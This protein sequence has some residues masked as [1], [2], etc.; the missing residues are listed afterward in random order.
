[1]FEGVHTALITPFDEAREFDETAFRAIIDEQFENGISGIVP[2]GTTGESPTLNNAEHRRV[3][4]HAALHVT[5]NICRSH[6]AFGVT[7]TVKT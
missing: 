6:A 1:M 5:T 7:D 2:V 3:I 4:L